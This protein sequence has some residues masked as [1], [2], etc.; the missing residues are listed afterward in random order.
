MCEIAVEPLQ[1]R[2]A[3]VVTLREFSPERAG[4]REVVVDVAPCMPVGHGRPLAA[5][6]PK[7]ILLSDLHPKDSPTAISC[8]PEYRGLYHQLI[9]TLSSCSAHQG[10]EEQSAQSSPRQKLASPVPHPFLT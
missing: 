4:F 2:H 3:V 8:Y 10:C 1:C 7:S 5:D 6:A 9:T